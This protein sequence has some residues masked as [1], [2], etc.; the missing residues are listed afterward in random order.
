M[1]LMPLGPVS[2]AADA[3]N[4]NRISRGSL[5]SYT[6]HREAVRELLYHQKWCLCVPWSG[7]LLQ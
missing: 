6:G 5:L 7:D 2:G 4:K 1:V 3:E